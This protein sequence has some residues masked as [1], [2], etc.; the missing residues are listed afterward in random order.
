MSNSASRRRYSNVLR[1]TEKLSKN[2]QIAT[3]NVAE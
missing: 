3:A 2:V 1:L